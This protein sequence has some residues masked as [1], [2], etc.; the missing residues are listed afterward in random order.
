MANSSP[1]SQALPHLAEDEIALGVADRARGTL[2]PMT[3]PRTEAEL[4]PVSTS[5]VAPET[6]RGRQRALA[7]ILVAAALAMVWV[8]SFL[9]VGIMLGMVM[10]FTAQPLYRAIAR[11]IGDR[12]RLAAAIVTSLY[13]LAVSTIGS[14]LLFA[15][16]RELFAIVNVA[17]DRLT[18]GALHQVIGERGARL[19]ARA[20]VD[21][22]V[23]IS[24]LR[25]ESDRLSSAAGDMISVVV[26]TTSGFIVG[27]IIALFTMYYVLLQWWNISIRLERVLPL[28]P[29]H[30]RALMVEFRDVGRSAFIGTIATAVLQG[31]LAGIAYALAGV[32]QPIAWALF[33]TLASFL[34]MIGTALVWLPIAGW[35]AVHD[36]LAS[37]LF[38][39][40]WGIAVVTSLT[41]YVVRPWLVGAQRHAHPLLMLVSLI[42]GFEAM[43]LAGLIVA[44]M[45]AS[46]FLAVF[47]IYERGVA[48]KR[49]AEAPN[50]GE[51]P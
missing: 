27:F 19:L 49:A 43:G 8:A 34:P 21:D 23:V 35:L 41:D 45:I 16:A 44:P 14:A 31:V 37:S 48:G 7:A 3:S 22:Q 47:N 39:L 13:A 24:R 38:V 51:Q 6:E 1:P 26:S 40:A 25:L 11:S 36:R 30:T 12:R 20:G 46:L 50:E 5:S 10:A 17:R 28:D 2:G 42:G 4:P 9:W 18:K 15:V 29:R 32:P 33:T